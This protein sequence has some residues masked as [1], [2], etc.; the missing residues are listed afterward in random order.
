MASVW[1]YS[2]CTLSA[3]STLRRVRCRCQGHEH[4]LGHCA[5]AFVKAGVGDI[6]AGQLAD[7]RLIFEE[8][9]Q[10]AL[11]GFGLIGR[12]GR[13]EFA[14][15]GDGIDDGRNEVVVAAAAQEAHSRIGRR[16]RLANL[17]MCCCNSISLRAGGISSGRLSRTAAGTC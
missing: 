4:R 13:V 2:G 8:R 14:A 6:H 9:L 12:V 15:A 16:L 7:Q 10:A 11:A 1:R 5:A 17:C 3:T